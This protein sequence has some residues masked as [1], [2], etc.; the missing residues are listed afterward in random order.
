MHRFT[1]EKRSQQQH[2]TGRNDL[3]SFLQMVQ[4]AKALGC[5]Y[6]CVGQVTTRQVSIA[7]CC[8]SSCIRDLEHYVMEPLTIWDP[9]QMKWGK[10]VR[11]CNL[12]VE[13]SIASAT[14]RTKDTTWRVLITDCNK[15]SHTVSHSDEHP[16]SV[17][18]PGAPVQPGTRASMWWVSWGRW[19]LVDFGKES[20]VRGHALFLNKLPPLCTIFSKWAFQALHRKEP[21]ALFLNVLLSKE[22]SCECCQIDP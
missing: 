16:L 18:Y 8:V 20:R 6:T 19:S 7:V 2:R 10:S 15:F 4:I 12:T 22:M 13:L 3:S 9:L 1:D 21:D 11:P 14:E 17:D 5:V